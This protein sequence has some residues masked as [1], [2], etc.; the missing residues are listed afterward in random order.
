M[1]AGC[2][3]TARDGV[4]LAYEPEAF[5]AALISR[6]PDIPHSL[7]EAPYLLDADIIERAKVHTLK[8]PRGP[9]RV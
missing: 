5:T 7:A 2:R 4:R 3:T 8:E 6:S 1:A 9:Q